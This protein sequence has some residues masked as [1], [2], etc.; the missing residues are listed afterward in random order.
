MEQLDVLHSLQIHLNNFLL[1]KMATLLTT[2]DQLNQI[3]PEDTISFRYFDPRGKKLN[4]VFRVK[5]VDMATDLAIV[6]GEAL[7]PY[8]TKNRTYRVPNLVI[9]DLIPVNDKIAVDDSEDGHQIASEAYWTKAPLPI[10]DMNTS[11]R[12]GQ[13]VSFN[14][15]TL[16]GIKPFRGRIIGMITPFYLVQMTSDPADIFGYDMTKWPHYLFTPLGYVARLGFLNN[17][18]ILET[19]PD[20]YFEFNVQGPVIVS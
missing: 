2:L 1:E 4:G 20:K 8:Y 18:V 12:I 15:Q 11:F 17:R 5:S 9:F 16:S 7:V 13:T 3:R 19:I 10:I 14:F 6:T